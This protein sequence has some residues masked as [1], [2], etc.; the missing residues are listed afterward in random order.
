MHKQKFVY[1][2]IEENKYVWVKFDT[3]FGSL[4]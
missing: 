2:H 3:K 4:G 1:Q